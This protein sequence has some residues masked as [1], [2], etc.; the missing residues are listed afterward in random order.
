VVQIIFSQLPNFHELW[1]LS[2]VAAIMSFSY[3]TIAIGLSLVQTIT[4]STCIPLIIHMHL[5]SEMITEQICT[6][7]LYVLHL[8]GPTGKTTLTGTVVGVDVDLEQK[9]WLTFQALGNIAF[10]YS[11]TIILIEIQVRKGTD[12][13][14]KTRES[15]NDSNLVT[16]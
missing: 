1:W 7:I 8:S 10:A 16:S 15:V 14:A 3:S 6:L 5:S 12:P 11:Y 2:V 13:A 9:I 4:G